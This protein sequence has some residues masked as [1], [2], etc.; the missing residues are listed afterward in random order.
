M[1]RTLDVQPPLDPPYKG[2]WQSYQHRQKTTLARFLRKV[3]ETP[4]PAAG[5][6]GERGRLIF[7]MDATASRE[8]HVGS[9]LSDPGRDVQ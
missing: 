9:S 6:T 1:T 8:P 7:A 5:A 4:A 2:G 3:S